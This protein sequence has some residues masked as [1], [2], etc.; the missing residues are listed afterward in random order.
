MTFHGFWVSVSRRTWATA[1]KMTPLLS[2]RRG[3]GW[4]V[5][6]PT[7]GNHPW[8]LLIKEGNHFQG[9]RVAKL[10]GYLEGKKDLLSLTAPLLRRSNLICRLAFF[11][12]GGGGALGIAD[13]QTDSSFPRMRESI[14][15]SSRFP[16]V[17]RWIPAFAGMTNVSR[18]DTGLPAIVTISVGGE[19]YG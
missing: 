17:A 4:W 12:A 7:P 1:L 5:V 15:S 13:S 8:P 9:F 6:S 19:P 18:L 11:L 14:G 10:G 16:D 3:R 2:G